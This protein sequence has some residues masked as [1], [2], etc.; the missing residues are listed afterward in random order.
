MSATPSSQRL[1]ALNDEF[2]KVIDRY[3]DFAVDLDKPGH[4][5]IM[6]SL[7]RDLNESLH[8]AKRAV[9]VLEL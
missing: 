2:A 8:R 7:C 6:K 1:T 9:R 5:E 3:A 4:E